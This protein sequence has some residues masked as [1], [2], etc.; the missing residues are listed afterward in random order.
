MHSLHAVGPI[1][2]KIEAF[3]LFCPFSPRSSHRMMCSSSR[4]FSKRFA[5]DA[6]LFSP[7]PM[8]L[9]ACREGR[10]NGPDR[11]RIRQPR[12]SRSSFGFRFPARY[13]WMTSGSCGR[14]SMARLTASTTFETGFFTL[15]I[16][17]LRYSSTISTA[18]ISG[19]QLAPVSRSH[20]AAHCRRRSSMGS[21]LCSSSTRS[22]RA[23][24]KSI[25]LVWPLAVGMHGITSL[26]HGDIGRP[27]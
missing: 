7:K 11:P 14:S 16:R 23:N 1:Q 18:R 13:G 9:A 12:A 26:A 27:F 17:S 24:L 3:P 6:P 8:I 21:W 20:R 22:A 10:R 4:R 15:F 25:S 19:L 5:T 2:L